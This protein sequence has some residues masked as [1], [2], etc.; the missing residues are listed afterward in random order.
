[1]GVGPYAFQ[2]YKQVSAR[3]TAVASALA[4]YNYPAGERIGFYSS[5]RAEWVISEYAC[6]AQALCTVP[7]YDTLGPEA[8]AYVIQQADVHLVFCSAEKVPSL[9]ALAKTGKMPLF[10]HVVVFATLPWEKPAPAV[11][12]LGG[13]TLTSFADFEKRGLAAPQPHRA[14]RPLDVATFCYTSGTTGDPKGA[15][16]THGGFM[17]TLAAVLLNAPPG[18]Y[19]P[20]DVHCSFMPLAHVYERIVLAAMMVVGGA[21]SFSR[22]VWTRVA[23]VCVGVPGC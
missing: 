12:D 6:F 3:V 19:G 10:K 11:A 7:M 22:G 17:V 13:L 1:M 21:S 16:L 5:N 4:A 20:E 15:M 8:A 2:T 14:P 23:V 18:A 9:V